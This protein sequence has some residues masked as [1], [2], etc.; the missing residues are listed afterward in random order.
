[1]V[2][3]ASCMTL[4][5]L[6]TMACPDQAKWARLCPSSVAFCSANCL[7]VL[8]SWY[9]AC[10]MPGTM[11]LPFVAVAEH[12]HVYMA[13][14]STQRYPGLLIKHKLT[15]VSNNSNNM[16]VDCRNQAS[17][18]YLWRFC[19]HSTT[20]SSQLYNLSKQYKIRHRLL[21]SADPRD[22]QHRRVPVHTTLCSF[23]LPK[24]KLK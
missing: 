12:K 9:I 18:I 20:H 5:L 22:K 19:T 3:T 8:L 6:L 13:S 16:H 11:V 23:W 14:L 21:F 17:I 7:A 24:P 10:T 1:M 2:S 15:V 4:R